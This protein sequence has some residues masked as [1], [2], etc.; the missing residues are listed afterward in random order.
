M[1]PF[2]LLPLG[3]EPLCFRP[4]RP[5][6]RSIVQPPPCW[7]GSIRAKEKSHLQACRILRSIFIDLS[8]WRYLHSSIAADYPSSIPLSGKSD[9]QCSGWRARRCH[10]R[11]IGRCY[12]WD[13]HSL[14]EPRRTN[15]VFHLLSR[16]TCWKRVPRPDPLEC[17]V[18]I[19][20]WPRCNQITA[21]SIGLS[22]CWLHR[23]PGGTSTHHR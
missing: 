19:R 12:A 10:Q 16:N 7:P 13:L 21:A 18:L 2:S 15:R 5:H 11:V 1:A 23:A 22:G 3:I 20:V 8:A 14:L 9:R 17:C 4:A 6:S